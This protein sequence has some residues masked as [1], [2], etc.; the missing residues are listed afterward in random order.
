MK[1]ARIRTVGHA[2]YR[3]LIV[4]VVGFGSGQ[5]SAQNPILWDTFGSDPDIQ[6]GGPGEYMSTIFSDPFMQGASF[7]LDTGFVSGDDEGAVIFNS[8]AGAVQSATISYSNIIGWFDYFTMALEID[9]LMVDQAF[10]IQLTLSDSG[11]HDGIGGV[12]IGGV[13]VPAGEGFTAS[14]YMADL[15]VSPGFDMFDVV[16]VSF[17]FNLPDSPTPSLDFVATEIRVIVPEPGASLLLGLGSL[18]MVRRCRS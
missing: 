4:F 8:G 17:Q 15:S 16:H 14:I 5:A 7:T 2:W 9:F 3:T 18:A 12:A 11:G 1:E 13:T 10:D 6:W